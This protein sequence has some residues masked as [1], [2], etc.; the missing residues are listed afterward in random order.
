MNDAKPV[1]DNAGYFE[2]VESVEAYRQ[3]G[4]ATTPPDYHRDR[5]RA[6]R[7]LVDSM[8]LPDTF[9]VIDFGCGDGMYFKDFFADYSEGRVSKIVGVD[10]SSPMIELAGQTLSGFPFEGHV[11]GA[12]AMKRI[13]EQFDVGLAIDVLGY[14]DDEELD[15]FYT[16]MA[17]LIR[18]GGYL[19]VMYG[20]ELFDM[21]ALNSG[22]ARFFRK[23]F[24][25]EVET[26][27]TEGAASQYE[28]VRRKNPLSFGAEIA[29][30]GFQ[31]V[32]QA[33]SQWHRVPPAIGNRA[34]D[35]AAA[36][37]EMRDHAFDPNDLEPA[38]RWKA[39][40]RS[41]IFASLSRKSA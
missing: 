34:A 32:S 14:L 21:F 20:N 10:L 17:R 1:G 18:P 29:P 27:L 2:S 24:D 22:T 35:L 6:L 38:Q 5:M 13:S 4:N 30:Y 15:V 7:L 28:P 37:L 39:L 26:L 41:S 23:H 9:Q 25:V 33:F 19:V 31:E 12:A 3:G 40:F 16:E 36:R 8:E 11:G